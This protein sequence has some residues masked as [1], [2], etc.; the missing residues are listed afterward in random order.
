MLKFCSLYSSSSGNSIFISD[1]K[2]RLLVDAGLSG[3]LIKKAIDDIDE[4][5]K[6][7]NG[8][9]VTHEHL[10][11]IQGVGVLSRKFDIPIYANKE[12][13]DGMEKYIGDIKDKNINYFENDNTFS[14]GEISIKAF[15]IPHDANNPVGFSME[16]LNKKI[17]IATD[18]GKMTNNILRNIENSD[19]LFLESNHDENILKSCKY[20]YSVKRRI[21]SD[22]GHLSNEIAGKAVAYLA[23]KGMERF[24]LCH[25]SEKSN[26]PELVYE[27]VKNYLLEKK[28]DIKK[29]ILL[30]IIGKKDTT[31]L[32]TM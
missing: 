9:L 1:N 26:F 32:N 8:I 4:N 7:V 16:L 21:L 27:T 30:N 12:T 10:D 3:K 18:I 19:I 24:I 17:S 23:E 6:N 29:D 31:T 2:S 11:H 20:P 15:S 22:K 5:L 25:L 13:W 14:I 28:I